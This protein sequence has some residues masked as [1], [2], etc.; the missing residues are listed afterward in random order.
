MWGMFSQPHRDTKGLDGTVRI[1]GHTGVLGPTPGDLL[2]EPNLYSIFPI[3]SNCPIDVSYM[4]TAISHLAIVI[5]P[6]SLIFRDHRG[7][8]PLMVLS[9]LF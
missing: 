1:F 7:C 3:V 5:F 2:S 9:M 8:L 4:A 6:R